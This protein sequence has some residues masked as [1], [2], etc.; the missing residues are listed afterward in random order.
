MFGL[1]FFCVRACVCVQTLFLRF[2]KGLHLTV[3][4]QVGVITAEHLPFDCQR[5]SRFA[6]KGRDAFFTYLQFVTYYTVVAV[7]WL[8]FT[9]CGL[10]LDMAEAKPRT[11]IS[12]IRVAEPSELQHFPVHRTGTTTA[13]LP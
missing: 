2:S 1:H 10:A 4:S 9:G 5:P 7:H 3:F 13:C 11:P 6:L 8:S 12:T